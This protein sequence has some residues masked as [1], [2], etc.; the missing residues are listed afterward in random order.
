VGEG[1]RFSLPCDRRL[2]S[3]GIERSGEVV[4]TGEAAEELAV[5][6]SATIGE[7]EKS[8]ERLS[9]AMVMAVRSSGG[10]KGKKR[11]VW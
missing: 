9:L 8:A 6:R 3:S 11:R 2:A 7:C 4:M 10:V 5:G 1:D